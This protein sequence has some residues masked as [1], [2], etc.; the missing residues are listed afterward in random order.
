MRVFKPPRLRKGRF[1]RNPAGLLISCHTH[2]ALP[3]RR[4]CVFAPLESRGL[5][6]GPFAADRIART[7]RPDVSTGRFPWREGRIELEGEPLDSAIAEFNRHKPVSLRLSDPALGRQKL[8]GSFRLNDP[9]GFAEAVGVSL[10]TGVKQGG[11]FTS[12][13]WIWPRSFA[14]RRSRISLTPSGRA[15]NSAATVQQRRWSPRLTETVSSRSW[16]TLFPMP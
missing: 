15:S 2:E 7:A 8:Y 4:R 14:R 3:R 1:P 9:H 12:S 10:D 11:C 16:P 6:S 5:R 13:V